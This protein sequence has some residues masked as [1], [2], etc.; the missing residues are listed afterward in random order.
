L[1]VP[2]ARRFLS[3]AS[4]K[5]GVRE[6][7]RRL[8]YEVV[9]TRDLEDHAL[10]RHLQDLFGTLAIRCVLDVGANRGQYRQ[11]LR[12]RV[13][14]DG[15]IISFEPVAANAA[16]LRA[17]AAGDAGWII[18]DH[19]LGAEE[20]E[21]EINV[22]TADSLSSFRSPAPEMPPMFRAV[23]VVERRERVA[24]R[25]LDAVIDE[26]ERGGGALGNIYL[27]LDTQGFDLEVVGGA[28]ATLGRVCALQTELSMRPLYRD[29][30]TYRETLDA[31]TARGFS[32][33]AICPV[34]RDERMRVVELDCVMVNDALPP[35]SC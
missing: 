27:K 17:A 12:D 15:L 8:G 30:P 32:V 6:A 5:R 21:A 3:R 7:V 28:A 31:L 11:F 19:A 29:A 26:V 1:W 23:N 16:G 4:F 18:R 20:G 13:G 14:Y 24:I 35:R 33:T 22:M 25:R 10:V 9:P 34:S 2:G